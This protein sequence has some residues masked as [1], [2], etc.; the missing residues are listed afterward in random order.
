ML[1]WYEIYYNVLVMIMDYES[2]LTHHIKQI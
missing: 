1:I 2:M